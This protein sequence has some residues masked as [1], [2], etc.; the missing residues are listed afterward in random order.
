MLPG[1]SQAAKTYQIGVPGGWGLEQP[2]AACGA[3]WR[4][5][6]ACNASHRGPLRSLQSDPCDPAVELLLDC[7]MVAWKGLLFAGWRM[8]VLEGIG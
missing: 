6:A 1:A 2:V 4:P 8:I 3:L 5:V 7:R